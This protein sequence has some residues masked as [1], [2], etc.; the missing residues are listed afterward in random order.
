M[1]DEGELLAARAVNEVLDTG[2]QRRDERL[3]VDSGHTRYKC[4]TLVYIN[5]N[6]TVEPA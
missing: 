6:I 2:R 1:K 4:D 3:H 5:K